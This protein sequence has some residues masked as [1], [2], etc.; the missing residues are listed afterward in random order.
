MLELAMTPS[1]LS[2]NRQAPPDGTLK[3]P[4]E[5]MPKVD[6]V[7]AI[8]HSE[9]FCADTADTKPG[10][11]RITAAAIAFDVRMK[12]LPVAFSTA[13]GSGFQCAMLIWIKEPSGQNPT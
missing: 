8:G 12:G 9:T 2:G 4:A 6:N 1:I 13:R 5:L 10:A 3:T 7:P 11:A